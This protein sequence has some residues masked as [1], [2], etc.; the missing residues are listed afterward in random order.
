LIGF[1]GM[2]ETGKTPVVLTGVF[3]VLNEKK[4]HLLLLEL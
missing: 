1:D 2:M 4:L 3:S